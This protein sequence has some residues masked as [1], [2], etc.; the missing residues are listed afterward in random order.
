MTFRFRSLPRRERGRRLPD[1]KAPTPHAGFPPYAPPATEV[2][3]LRPIGQC[4]VAL[5]AAV[6]ARRSPT[7]DRWAV[8]AKCLGDGRYTLP[9]VLVLYFASLPTGWTWGQETALLAFVNFF[10]AGLITQILH[11]LTRRYRPDRGVGPLIFEGVQLRSKHRS[12]PSGHST[13]SWAVFAIFALRCWPTWWP[14]SILCLLL[15]LATAYSRL[16]DNAHWPSDV[17]TGSLIGLGTA[18]ALVAWV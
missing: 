9:P 13:V 14:L 4:D 8:W 6:Q 17:L 3:W 5:L 10:F 1:V 18:I 7:S 12:F 2:T 16:N 15:P 11:I